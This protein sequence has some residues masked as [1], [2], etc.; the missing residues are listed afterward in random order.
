MELLQDAIDLEPDRTT[1]ERPERA[2]AIN[3]KDQKELKPSTPSVPANG[4]AAKDS[5][6][7]T[8][9]IRWPPLCPGF[10]GFAANST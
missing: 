7:R 10:S 2:E 5:R 9:S 6:D 4:R 1:V 3:A 8:Q